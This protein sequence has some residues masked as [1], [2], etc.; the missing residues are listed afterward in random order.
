[1]IDRPCSTAADP[2]ECEHN[3]FVPAFSTGLLVLFFT[4]FFLFWLEF[5]ISDL[6]TRVWLTVYFRWLSH[7]VL[8][9][10]LNKVTV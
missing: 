6:C 1:M 2:K 3:T 4:L 5:H 10:N 9:E 8:R 7:L